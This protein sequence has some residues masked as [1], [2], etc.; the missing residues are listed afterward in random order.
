VLALLLI[1]IAET[2]TGQ[3]W[4]M[5]RE[6]LQRPHLGTFT[7]PVGS[8]RQRTELTT[9]QKKILAALALPE[10]RRVYEATPT[11]R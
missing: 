8:F 4:T 9:G 5:L 11:T 10:P 6:E 1:R 3:T 7:G 2:G